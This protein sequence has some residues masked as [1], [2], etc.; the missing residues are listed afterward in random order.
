MAPVPSVTSAV[1]T[2]DQ[3]MAVESSATRIREPG[4]GG[5]AVG[6]GGGAA[7]RRACRGGAAARG[8]GGGGEGRGLGAGRRRAAQFSRIR[9]PNP[10]PFCERGGFVSGPM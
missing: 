7:A 8:G 3:S 10:A 2:A 1:R 5:G 6:G 9:P 4:R